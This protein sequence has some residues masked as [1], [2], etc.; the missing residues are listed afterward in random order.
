MPGTCEVLSL[1][2]SAKPQKQVPKANHCLDSQPEP[3][4][5]T[6]RAECTKERQAQTHWPEHRQLGRAYVPGRDSTLR[7]ILRQMDVNDN[8]SR[9]G[10]QMWYEIVSPQKQFQ[11]IRKRACPSGWLDLHNKIIPTTPSAG[12][13]NSSTRLTY[14]LFY[15]E[16]GQ[17]GRALWDLASCFSM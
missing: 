5:Y 17:T 9:P 3:R 6:H 14:R 1:N 2:H 4:Y 8:E 11:V 13:G 12:W 15:R 16:T 7:C 10:F